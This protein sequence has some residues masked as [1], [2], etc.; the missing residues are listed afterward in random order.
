M[1]NKLIIGLFITGLILFGWMNF[2]Y[3]PEKENLQ[4]E[5]M[6]RQLDPET[7]D[8]SKVIVYENL[9]MGNISNNA[10]LFQS[11]PLQN[12]LNG[13]EQ[14]PDRF[15]LIV[16][17][18]DLSDVSTRQIHQSVIYNTTVAFVLIKNLEQI[19][20]RLPNETF[21][22]NRSNVE[23]IL[24]NLDELLNPQLFEK[25]VQ[26]RLKTEEIEDWMDQYLVNKE[27]LDDGTCDSS[28]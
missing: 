6:L 14:D 28:I 24:G 8:F 1:K 25:E 23:S 3:I 11:L 7:H 15:L 17:Y 26:Q 12:Y 21:L 20:L 4:A 5:E 19:E 16:N 9:Y 22:V 13:Y 2:F 27:E 18:K 10:H